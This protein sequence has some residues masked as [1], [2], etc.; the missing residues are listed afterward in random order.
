M[1]WSE[2]DAALQGKKLK[3]KIGRENC[4]TCRYKIKR[5]VGGDGK[6]SW[7]N[8]EWKF[9]THIN[10]LCVLRFFSLFLSKFL[11]E[12]YNAMSPPRF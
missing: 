6:T 1:G 8:K 9:H 2:A 11:C 7:H 10:S 4:E 12:T 3:G 5:F